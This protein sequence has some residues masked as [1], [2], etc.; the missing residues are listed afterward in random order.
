[1]NKQSIICLL[2]IFCL[3]VTAQNKTYY[4]S[5]AGNDANNGLTTATAW[6]TLSNINN[7]NLK[8]G[9]KILLEGGQVFTGSIQLDAADSGSAVNPITVTSY[10]SGQATISA[11]NSAAIYVSNTG[12]LNINHLI[13]KG[14]GSDHDGIDV[15]LNQTAA[16]IEHIYVDSVEVFGFGRRGFLLG[17]Y[18]TDKGINHVNVQ[19]SS[20][21]DNGIAGLETFGAWP[22]ISNSDITV[23]Y[24]KFYNNLGQLNSTATTGTGIVVSGFDGGVIEYCEAYNNGANNRSPG[25]GPVG[26]W[27]Y[28]TKN[29][30]IQYCESHHNKAGLLKDGGGFDIDGG[31]QNCTV[32]YCYSHDNEGYGFALVEY[33]SPN[34]FT[35]NTI[36]YNVSQ[37]DARKNSYGAII[38]YAVDASHVV[39]NSDV[40]N[41][42]IYVDANNLVDGKPSA[43]NILSQNFSNVHVRN[44]IFYVTGGVDMINSLY[45]LPTSEL[46]LQYNNYFSSAST[47]NFIWNGANYT[48]LTDWETSA[49][50][51]ETDAGLPVAITQNPLLMDAG[52]GGTIQPAD[53]GRFTA[54]FGY[55]LNPFSPV[56]D[57]ALNFGNMGPHDFFGNALP[58]SS[59][60]DVG[61]AEA[62]RVEV[63]PLTIIHF[64]G[65]AQE[66]NVL[67]QWQVTNEEYLDR[68][69]IQR[70]DNDTDFRTMD[71]L[72]ANAKH[73]YTFVDKS[74]RSADVFYRLR[75]VYPNGRSGFSNT[76]KISKTAM[77]EPHAFYREG[78][79]ARI[80]LYSDKEKKATL[81]AYSSGGSLLYHSSCYLYQGINL[82]TIAEAEKWNRGMY[83]I[84]ITSDEAATLQFVK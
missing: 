66:Q 36:R 80:E 40:Y 77:K 35:G 13:L 38:L 55:S 41:N 63:L 83:F 18:N 19:H 22:S 17:A 4:I 47:Y 39:K 3:R 48:S 76:I 26:I 24:C 16:G 5:A 28:D 15:Y 69:E 45:A 33:G 1:M 81:C 32:Q 6:Q 78:Q 14:D 42:T 20:F 82:V 64:S 25:G 56:V 31:S 30:V 23:R 60:F 74:T 10:G 61:A 29:V 59:N 8:A 50:G 46:Y 57:K 67:L 12:G 53:G 51:Q 62:I 73:K 43:L 11:V 84:H 79:G 27:V 75:Y 2:L 54:L 37:N 58:S 72:S 71:H 21:H 70:S 7:L 44:N 34:E 52:K 68:Y 9:D 65:E 49:P